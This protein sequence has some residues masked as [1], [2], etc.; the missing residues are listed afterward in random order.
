MCISPKPNLNRH[1][2]S[3]SFQPFLCIVPFPCWV[4]PHRPFS[5]HGCGGAL[6]QAPPPRRSC[7][8]QIFSFWLQLGDGDVIKMFEQSISTNCTNKLSQWGDM[9]QVL[10]T[11]SI[12]NDTSRLKMLG[13]VEPSRPLEEVRGRLEAALPKA[14]HGVGDSGALFLKGET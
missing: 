13:H 8:W 7:S 6:G 5:Q 9:I 11:A 14:L 10:S 1:I 4:P 12:I 3:H 2:Q